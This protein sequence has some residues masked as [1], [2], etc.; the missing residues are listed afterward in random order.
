MVSRA[1]RP[2][3]ATHAPGETVARS[4]VATWLGRVDAICERVR[5]DV[6]E[7]ERKRPE[8]V[9]LSTLPQ[10]QLELPSVAQ[11]GADRPRRVP[12]GQR[13]VDVEVEEQLD[14]QIKL[15]PLPHAARRLRLQILVQVLDDRG[16]DPRVA[17]RAD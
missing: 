4:T 7:R 16:R 2:W 6:I 9:S 12:L 8:S 5:V 13:R 14:R 17:G 11:V 3:F 1:C 15:P 10:R